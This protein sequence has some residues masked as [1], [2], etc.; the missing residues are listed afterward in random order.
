MLECE[1]SSKH[2]L[3]Y[4]I[5]ITAKPTNEIE[6]EIKREKERIYTWPK[7][8]CFANE[9][10]QQQTFCI[11]H[12]QPDASYLLSSASYPFWYCCCCCHCY[13]H[14]NFVHKQKPYRKL[15]LRDELAEKKIISFH[16]ILG[17]QLNLNE[18]F[19]ESTI[20]IYI[21]VWIFSNL[22]TQTED[23]EIYCYAFVTCALCRLKCF[24][25]LNFVVYTEYNLQ[26]IV[27]IRRIIS[28][29]SL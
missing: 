7:C 6:K 28:F 4:R 27:L 22:R 21:R 12:I 3:S 13:C 16:F 18:H 2:Q 5:K 26:L 1:F 11:K 23:Y 17:S 14:F 29:L 24:F 20:H 25:F 10:K 8:T 19:Y 15:L 9:W